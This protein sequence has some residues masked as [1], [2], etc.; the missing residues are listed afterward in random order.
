MAKEF[1]F[2]DVGEGITEGEIVKWHV[3]EGDRVKED[4]VIA[5]IETDKAVVELPS[6]Y[7]GVV[8]K[9]HFKEGD[10]VKVGESLVTIGEKGEAVEKPEGKAE[11][12][13]R[14]V[15]VVGELEEAP[16]EGEILATPAVRKLAKELGVD[17]AGVKG[18]GRGGRITREDVER[19]AKPRAPKVK[20]TRKYDMYGHI[21]RV[22][23]RSVRRATA[24]KMTQAW[25][26]IPH[27]THMD[28]AD[29]THL[30]EVRAKY[31]KMAEERGLKLTFLPFIVKAVTLALKEHPYL[32]ATMDEETNEI[33]L[34]HYY[35]IGIAVDTGEGLV[36]PVIK[37]CDEK[38]VLEIAKEIEVLAEKTRTRKI[39]LMDLKGGTFTITNIGAI[40]GT[41]A[42]PIINYPEVAILGTGKIY[43][44]PIVKDGEI[45]IRKVLPLSLSFDHR[46]I[47]GAEA[48]RFMNDVMRRLSDP[49]ILII[50]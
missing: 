15:A 41:F 4:D 29:I 39:D 3:S 11:E 35:N 16:E 24:K 25:E 38:S 9:I 45:V 49:D 33:I 8:L 13:L 44:K 22:P 6:P 47:D 28:E 48:A 23:I 37:G 40:G 20:V 10:I 42:T 14:A 34:K 21:K 7:S 46:V 19:A 36:V 2:P 30:F 27:V 17:L 1:K 18:T 26:K 12:K 43:E 31:K 50:E 32:N 5:E